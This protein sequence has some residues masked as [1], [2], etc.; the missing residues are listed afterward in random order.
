M[1]FQIAKLARR[2]EQ[3]ATLQQYETLGEKE[4]TTRAVSPPILSFDLNLRK[5]GD[6][7]KPYK[8]VETFRFDNNNE[9]ARR[10]LNRGIVPWLNISLFGN[11]R[12]IHQ[13]FS[14]FLEAFPNSQIHADTKVQNP[15]LELAE[16]PWAGSFFPLPSCC[17]FGAEFS[18][19]RFS[20]D[21][22]LD[23]AF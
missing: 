22:F 15:P 10:Y 9:V 14:S 21:E 3:K 12:G 2:P 5:N 11:T 1:S 13:E 4:Q 19:L 7:R 20:K 8:H 18:P 23:R 6:S 17:L 16:V